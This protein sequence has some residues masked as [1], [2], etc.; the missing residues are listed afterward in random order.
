LIRSFL[1]TKENG[2][3]IFVQV[4]YL[5]LVVWENLDLLHHVCHQVI[6]AT[7]TTRVDLQGSLGSHETERPNIHHEAKPTISS[8]L[9]TDWLITPSTEEALALLIVYISLT[10]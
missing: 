4:N 8:T 2:F 10:S 1:D 7:V 5:R 6:V 9:T 3:V